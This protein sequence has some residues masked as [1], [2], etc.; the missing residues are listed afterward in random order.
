MYNR[1]EA[2]I[3]KQVYLTQ[4]QNEALKRR[5]RELGT[6]EAEVLRQIVDQLLSRDDEAARR[7]R[8]EA[9][10]EFLDLADK[11]VAEGRGLPPGYKF[12]REEVYRERMEKLTR[13]LRSP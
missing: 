13:R 5:A 10:R 6:S 4:A 11:V 3:R 7:T 12:N 9:M 2:V 1:Q 8:V